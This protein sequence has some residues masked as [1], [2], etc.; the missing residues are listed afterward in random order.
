MKRMARYLKP[1]IAAVPVAWLKPGGM[2][3]PGGRTSNPRTCW[4]LL[5]SVEVREDLG[6]V[7][8]KVERGVRETDWF[9]PHE[10]V[11]VRE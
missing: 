2:R 6:K 4:A 1:G 11:E 10:P 3:N 5:L 7:L 9:R 8:V